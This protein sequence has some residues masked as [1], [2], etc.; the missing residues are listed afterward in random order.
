MCDG[1]CPALAR[2]NTANL[3]ISKLH[4]RVGASPE[5]K[6]YSDPDGCSVVPLEYSPYPGNVGRV[7]CEL[8]SLKTIQLYVLEGDGDGRCLRECAIKLLC[9]AFR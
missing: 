8:I 9:V 6:S 4:L 5:I 3:K 7:Y 1:K 2:T